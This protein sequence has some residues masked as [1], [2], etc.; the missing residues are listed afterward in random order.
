MESVIKALKKLNNAAIFTHI[1]PD[2]DA[3][4]SALSL[5]EV[6]VNMGKKAD[7]YISD[8]VPKRLL[9]MSEDYLTSF[10][11]K[12]YDTLISLD[13]GDL[14]RLS[15]YGEIFK[16]HQNTISIDHHKTNS[17]FA[18]INYVLPEASSTGEVLYD[19]FKKMG[20]EISKKT[21]EYLYCAIASDT[22]CF[23][24]S[25]TGEKGH[26]IAADL[27]KKG[28]DFAELNRLLFDTE[29][30]VS[31][32]LKGYAMN[33]AELHLGGKVSTVSI[34]KEDLKKLGADFEHT[35]GL[36]DVARIIEG[37]EVGIVL[38]E[39]DDLV[40]VSIRTNRYVDA[41]VLASIF[42]GGGHIRASGCVSNLSIEETKQKLV[43]KAQELIKD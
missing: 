34:T 29:E 11:D 40:K 37:V 8:N 38:K 10:V 20:A 9:F 3:F 17:L 43:K 41:T 42:G 32:K 35:E 2:G 15:E 13:A 22:G 23:K 5:K 14:K 4:G 39:K 31:Y 30:V 18:K 21:A 1:M 6:L 36:S 25:S 16:N 7:I 12:G 26:L 27:I 33:K 24:F 28:I 19:I